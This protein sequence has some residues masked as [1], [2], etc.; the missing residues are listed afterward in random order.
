MHKPNRIRATISA[1][2]VF[3][4]TVVLESHD[5]LEFSSLF[6]FGLG[7]LDAPVALCSFGEPEVA[8]SR[9]ELEMSERAEELASE[10]PIPFAPL[11][12]PE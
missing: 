7:E 4:T 9:I 5:P 10:I 1:V 6:A 11:R 8:P 3:G 2:A 12:V